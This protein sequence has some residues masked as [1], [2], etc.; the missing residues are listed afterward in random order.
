[1]TKIALALTS[2]AMMLVTTARADPNL[3]QGTPPSSTGPYYPSVARP[4]L[5]GAYPFSGKKDLG[6][7][8]SHVG[9]LDVLHNP[10]ND[11]F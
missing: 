7:D 2:A 1:M 9:P 8:A 11:E 4:A 5:T 10:P 3:G 6:I